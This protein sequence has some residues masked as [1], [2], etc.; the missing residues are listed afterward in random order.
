MVIGKG[1]MLDIINN[2]DMNFYASI[3]Y[4]A[5]YN[6]NIESSYM[7]QHIPFMESETGIILPE[8]KI[9]FSNN[10]TGILRNVVAV[11][12]TYRLV[13][14]KAFESENMCSL[15]LEKISEANITEENI[16]RNY[17]FRGG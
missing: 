3:P 8:N 16:A 5:S 10:E 14:P 2:S 12:D 11:D 15:D 4:G 6:G 1:Y 13:S 17:V 7:F 9:L